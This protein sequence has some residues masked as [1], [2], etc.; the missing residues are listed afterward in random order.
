MQITGQTTCAYCGVDL[1]ISFDHW[2]QLALDHVVPK[3][4]CKQFGLPGCWTEDRINKVLACAACNGWDNRYKPP[5]L[6]MCPGS[7]HAF[8]QLRDRIFQDRQA[9][10]AE[11]R[12]KER[13]FFDQRLWERRVSQPVKRVKE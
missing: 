2:L 10:V 3:G 7:L 11:C 5:A 1:V 12:K 13:E 8:C 9:R 6:T 4:V